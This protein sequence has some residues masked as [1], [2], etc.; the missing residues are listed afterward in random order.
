MKHLYQANLKAFLREEI[1]KAAAEQKLTKEQAAEILGID[2][3][4]YAY[5]KAG[6]NMCSA[7]TLILFLTRMCPD[8][9]AFIQAAKNAVD[10]AEEE[11]F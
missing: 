7:S 4:S 2:A 9:T 10:L 6:K 11:I 3:R 8:T 1:I 5:L